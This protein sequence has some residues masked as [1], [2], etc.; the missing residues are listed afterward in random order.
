MCVVLIL[1]R[2]MKSKKSDF[3]NIFH[4]RQYV[5]YIFQYVI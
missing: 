1:S 5:K 4:L 2:H 3:N